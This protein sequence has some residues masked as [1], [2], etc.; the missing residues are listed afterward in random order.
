MVCGNA[1]TNCD[2]KYCKECVEE[3]YVLI[4]LLGLNCQRRSTDM[5]HHVIGTTSVSK[6][7]RDYSSVQSV[8]VTAIV[9]LVWR[10][11][12]LSRSYI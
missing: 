7:I 12:S 8:K 10:R 5:P 1:K 11:V 3:R 2:L 6:R 9:R 4:F